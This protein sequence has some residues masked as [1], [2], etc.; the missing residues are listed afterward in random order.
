VA[1]GSACGLVQN[2][3]NIA[4]GHSCAQFNQGT[5]AIAIGTQAG[6]ANQSS[7]SIAIGLFAGQTN[8]GAYSVAIGYESSLNNQGSSCVSI[9]QYSGYSNQGNNAIAIGVNSAPYTQGLNS[10]AVGN[11]AGYQ[12]QGQYAISLGY[13]AGYTNQGA[14]SL[15][16]G[17][18]AG[19]DTL[20]VN[21]IAIGQ[22]SG[23]FSQPANTICINAS[24]IA[25]TPGNASSFVVKPVRND[26]SYVT[27][28]PYA[29]MLNT[30]TNEIFTN[31]NS[32]TSFAL[33]GTATTLFT[34]AGGGSIYKL[35]MNAS[36]GAP[37]GTYGSW[38]INSNQTIISSL[39]SNN[40]TL[41]FSGLNIQ[42][43]SGNAVSYTVTYL[44]YR[45][46]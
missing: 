18:L 23:L 10:I 5:F 44:V 43:K 30:S 26:S 7:N 9:G 33:T 34:S 11:Q 2:G 4:I 35:I 45:I 20:G 29:L 24:G 8:Q 19:Y 13:Q 3:E 1:I 39:G 37:N 21:S 40:I 22:N 32:S 15:A 28:I 17:T 14:N 12:S 31:A 16:I 38:I 25:I 41:T 46:M 27:S 42:A 36:V 6:Q